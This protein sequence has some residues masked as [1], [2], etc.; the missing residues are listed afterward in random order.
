MNNTFYIKQGSTNPALQFQVR[1]KTS[2]KPVDITGATITFSMINTADVAVVE[3]EDGSVV[4]GDNG[5]GKYA[6][7]EEDTDTVG[8]YRGEFKVVLTDSSIFRVP[9]KGYI[10]IVIGEAITM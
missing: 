5:I 1:E 7:S 6:W 2:K 3:N 10:P 9:E 4:D 8:I